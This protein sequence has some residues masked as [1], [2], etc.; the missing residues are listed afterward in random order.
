M[1]GIIWVWQGLRG[2]AGGCRGPWGKRGVG[3][4]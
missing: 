3:A 1:G 2:G 4:K